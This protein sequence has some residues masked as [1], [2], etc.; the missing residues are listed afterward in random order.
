MES[1]KKQLELFNKQMGA[2]TVTTLINKEEITHEVI[3]KKSVVN[4][5]DD[6]GNVIKSV[7]ELNGRTFITIFRYDEDGKLLEKATPEDLPTNGKIIP[8]KKVE[9]NIVRESFEY[10]E[11]GRLRLSRISDTDYTTYTYSNDKKIALV[12]IKYEGNRRFVKEYDRKMRVTRESY[13]ESSDN[14][15]LSV[16][17][18]IKET[19]IIYGPKYTTVTLT[20]N[21]AQIITVSKYRASDGII[22]SES[23]TNGKDKK[24]RK[25]IFDKSNNIIG[26]KEYDRGVL[27]SKT[28]FEV[29]ENGRMLSWTNRIG[30]VYGV[31]KYPKDKKGEDYV[32]TT[33]YSM[34]DES[35]ISIENFK[36]DA[37][38]HEEVRATL[39]GSKIYNY[40]STENDIM[41][42]YDEAAE[43]ISWGF[44][45][46]GIKAV[47]TN[48]VLKLTYTEKVDG[49]STEYDVEYFI[50]I[51][52]T[53]D[54]YLYLYKIFKKICP[55]KESRS[56]FTGKLF[57]FGNT[58]G[59]E[60][61][62]GSRKEIQ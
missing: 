58:L 20:E 15:L 34:E 40:R 30:K 25:A 18:P 10:D 9:Q 57:D 43:N 27:I 33:L 39:N 59:G 62:A 35:V 7:Q 55:F 14:V 11:N 53:N 44:D 23:I 45:K 60:P 54:L 46:Y 37:S 22:I 6:N 52:Q 16:W 49:V 42:I 12:V 36:E 47:F 31:Y 2:K 3:V 48:N 5:L 61:N 13:Q 1:I 24:I 21:N 8:M 28:M 50:M 17:T 56:Y 51:P 41:L 26:Y 32:S 19:N 4:T 29:D 38:I